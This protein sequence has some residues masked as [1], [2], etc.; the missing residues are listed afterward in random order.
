MKTIGLIVNPVAGMGGRVGLKGSDGAE[1]LE[2]ARALG[3]VPEAPGRVVQALN[4]LAR[5]RARCAILTWPGDMGEVE[6]REA[7]FEPE[8]IG[9]IEPGETSPDDTERAAREM[10]A[11]GVDL[12]LFA[13]G[14]GTARNIFHAVGDAVPVLGIPAG[15]KIHSGVYAVTPRGA[16]EVAAR[17]VAGGIGKFR[18]AEVMDID[19][20]AFREGQVSAKLYGYMRVPEENRFVQSVKAGGRRTERETLAGIAH[21]VVSRMQGD[22]ERLYIIGPGTTTRAVM[23]ELGLP[24]SLLG[25]DVVQAG[26]LVASD[27]I[28]SDL[29][30]LVA[31]TPARIVVTVIGGQGHMFGRGNQQLS[32]RV[33]RAVGLKNITVIATQDKLV[34]LGGRPLLVDTGDEGLNAALSGYARV[35]TGYHDYT[36]FRVGHDDAE[37]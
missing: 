34:A 12:L 26:K 15:V 28:E 4:V 13:G 11:R 23:E 5:E 24:N 30:A 1:I 32:P 35:V 16:G 17:F 2:R 6:A 27:V 14:D 29:M 10:V 19:E 36:M 31:D 20:A 9:S 21:D 8:V 18:D 3:A 33:L 37:G 7:G 25:V 22:D